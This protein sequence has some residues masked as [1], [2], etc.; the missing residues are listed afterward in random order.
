MG[1]FGVTQFD[2][3]LLPDQGCILAIGATWEKF[4][5]GISTMKLPLVTAACVHH[6][7]H[8]ADMAIFLQTLANIIENKAEQLAR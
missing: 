8:G 7:I 2:P 4:A 6:E 1:M 3:I 5:N